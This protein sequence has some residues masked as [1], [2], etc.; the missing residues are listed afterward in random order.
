M[1]VSA[2]IPVAGKGKRFG[3]NT[4]KQYLKVGNQTVI[5]ITLKKFITLSEVNF[6]VIVVSEADK[7]T[8]E[9]LF[10]NIDGFEKKFKVV[11]GGAERQDSVYNGLVAVPP[12]TDIVIVHD[13]VRPLVSSRLI[14]NSIKSAVKTGAC[15]AALPVKDTIKRVKKETVLETIPREDLWHIQTPQTFNYK[16]LMD[17]HIRAKNAD[18]YCTD[19]SALVEWSGHPVSIIPGELQNIKITTTDDL[20]FCRYLYMKLDKDN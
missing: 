3:G 1:I 11:S 7:N 14:R 18:Y 16:V 2:I 6:G 4:P 9:K 5:E 12:E 17:A 13:G 19:E 15:I 20:E 8:S 10:D